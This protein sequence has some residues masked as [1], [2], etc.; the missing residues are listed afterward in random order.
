MIEHSPQQ[1]PLFEK[2]MESLTEGSGSLQAGFEAPQ[3]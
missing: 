1:Q 3:L 2:V